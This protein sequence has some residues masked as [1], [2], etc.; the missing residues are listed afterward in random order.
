VTS[1]FKDARLF[2]DAVLLDPFGKQVVTAQGLQ[3]EQLILNVKQPDLWWPRNYGG[4][5]LYTLQVSLISS[6]EVVDRD[7]KRLGLR[8]IVS[9]ARYSSQSTVFGYAYG[10]RA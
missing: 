10:V 9:V 8:E 7:E 6:G 1:A 3:G 5:P 4:Q 2:V